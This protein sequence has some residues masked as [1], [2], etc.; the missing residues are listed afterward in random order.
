ERSGKNNL[1][2][3]DIVDS[4]LHQLT[5]GENEIFPAC[6]PDGKWVVFQRMAS[7]TQA[8]S[9]WKVSIDGGEP[10]RVT[11][12]FALRP[13]ISPDGKW[14]AAFYMDDPTWRIGLIPIE[15]GRIE[16]SFD[17]PPGMGDRIARWAPDGRALLL[18]GNYGDVGNIWR[19]PIE[20]GPA[21]KV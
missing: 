2:R 8:T 4:S 7:A 11:D 6:T 21:E 20:G 14:I 9:L 19:I 12:Y 1:W 16:K 18:V 10:K 15:G 3:L 5:Y 17:L 13:T